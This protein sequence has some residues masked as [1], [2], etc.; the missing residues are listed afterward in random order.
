[1][2]PSPRS[3][4]LV[5]LRGGSNPSRDRPDP[6]DTARAASTRPTTHGVRRH[7]TPPS[8]S[9][10]RGEMSRHL[11][12]EVGFAL[13]VVCDTAPFTCGDAFRHLSCKI[14]FVTAVGFV[15]SSSF[16]ACGDSSVSPS[17]RSLLHVAMTSSPVSGPL[18]LVTEW[19]AQFRRCR[20][21]FISGRSRLVSPYLSGAIS[22]A[23]RWEGPTISCRVRA[24][25][26]A[27]IL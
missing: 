19:S 18:S 15:S 10:S 9:R 14:C 27:D 17:Y 5:S 13:A 2:T 26:T 16:F 20:I 8:P 22:M 12:R 4:T 25:S 6:P 21:C 7:N 3:T 1:M 24:S 11:C 23:C